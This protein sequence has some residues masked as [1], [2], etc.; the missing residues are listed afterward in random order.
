VHL[1]AVTDTLV[2]FADGECA[3]VPE[4]EAD[5]GLIL[6][7][8]LPKVPDILAPTIGDFLFKRACTV[9]SRYDVLT[10]GPGLRLTFVMH[11]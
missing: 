9:G 2:R 3:I 1:D 6:R 10:I 11:D 8:R 4:T 5:G 7:V